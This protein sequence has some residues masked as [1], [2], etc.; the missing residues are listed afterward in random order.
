MLYK[1][2]DFNEDHYRGS[3]LDDF[4]KNEKHHGFSDSE[5]KTVHEKMQSNGNDTSKAG[6]VQKS[7]PGSTDTGSNASDNGKV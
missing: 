2:V 7:K 3:K 5:M 6:A 1:D 4:I